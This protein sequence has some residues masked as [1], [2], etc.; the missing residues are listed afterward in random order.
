LE[1]ICRQLYLA[2]EDLQAKVAERDATIADLRARLE[3]CGNDATSEAENVVVA[4][5][6][7]AASANRWMT[8]ELPKLRTARRRE[9]MQRR[10]TLEVE[11]K[12]MGGGPVMAT[13]QYGR[14]MRIGGASSDLKKVDDELMMIRQRRWLPMIA[15]THE[16]SIGAISDATSYQLQPYNLE[17]L[18]V[19]NEREVI[20]EVPEVY[21]QNYDTT[22]M[23]DGMGGVAKDG[24]GILPGLFI[25]RGTKQYPTANGSTRTIPLIEP[26][27]PLADLAGE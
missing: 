4:A 13:D 16:G 6:Q 21:I 7:P 27:P 24:V 15:V 11:V 20:M 25:A 8:V 17:V 19:V 14:T 18:Q 5:T 23:F 1:A 26:Y 12:E 3:A 22:G 10:T 9:L 2:V